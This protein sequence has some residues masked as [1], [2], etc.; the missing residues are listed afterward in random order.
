MGVV[1]GIDLASEEIEQLGI[2]LAH[3][4]DGLHLLLYER[5]YLGIIIALVL[6]AKDEHYALGHAFKSIPA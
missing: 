4:H 6:A 2:V 3:A 5:L 1:Y